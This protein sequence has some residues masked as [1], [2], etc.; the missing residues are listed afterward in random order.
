MIAPSFSVQFFFLTVY[1][2]I[3]LNLNGEDAQSIKTPE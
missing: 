1:K 2:W 3:H